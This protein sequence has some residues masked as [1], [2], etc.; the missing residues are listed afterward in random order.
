LNLNQVTVP[1]VDV[2]ASVAF[3]KRLGLRLIVD[4]VPRYARFECPDG[5][6]TFSIHRV[7]E[8]PDTSGLT[9]YFECDDLDE[10]VERLHLRGVEFESA[11]TD[12][13]WLWR[14]ARLR[15]PSGNEICLFFG[16]ENRRYPAWRI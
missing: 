11:P 10:H 4:S 7:G 16:G 12:E 1:A 6:A 8:Q 2:A 3:Y 5:E 9:V 14:E 13:R 15:D